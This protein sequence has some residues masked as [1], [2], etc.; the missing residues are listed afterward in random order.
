MNA[1]YLKYSPRR[2]MAIAALALGVAVTAYAMPPRGGD[3]CRADTG[4]PGQQMSRGLRGMTQLH[5]N[6]KLDAKQEALWKEAENAQ[7]ESMAG[8]RDRFRQHH[9]E[10]Q[11]MI[12]K[13]GADLRAA[14]KRMD[15]FKAEGQKLHEANRD[16]W[17]AV[18]DSLNAEQ[19]EQ[20]RLFFKN[21]LDNMRHHGPRGQRGPGQG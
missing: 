15:D 13:P 21:K 3:N 8:M 2:A 11:A 6:L 9:E 12:D 5:D 20:A 1:K 7:K 14:A 4:M 18:Y 17:L 16:R 19:K 10:I